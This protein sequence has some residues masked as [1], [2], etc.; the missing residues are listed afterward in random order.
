MRCRPYPAFFITLYLILFCTVG[1]S[2]AQSKIT[3]AFRYDDFS[4]ISDSVIEK[5]VAELF[6]KYNFKLTAGVIPFGIEEVNGETRIHPLTQRKGE[7]LKEYSDKGVFDIALHGFNHTWRINGEFAG[8]DYFEQKN[9]LSDGRQQIFDAVGIEASTFIPPWNRNDLNTLKALEDLSFKCIS[10][11]EHCPAK[12]SST[13]SFVPATCEL[14]ELKQA[15]E[16]SRSFKDERPIIVVLFHSED[17]IEVDKDFGSMSLPEL[18]QLLNWIAAQ[19][20]I[21]VMSISDIVN[22]KSCSAERYAKWKKTMLFP[23]LPNFHNY[24]NDTIFFSESCCGKVKKT[25]TLIFFSILFAAFF[26]SFFMGRVI[27]IRSR[28]VFLFTGIGIL[29]AG[30]LLTAYDLKNDQLSPKLLGCLV[31]LLSALIG[32]TLSYLSLRRKRAAHL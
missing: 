25:N 28:A 26:V 32:L 14:T 17:F 18:D 15:I 1:S 29:S 24:F 10:S 21:Q 23:R 19:N 8:L 4:E 6:Q 2:L 13:L 30:C 5:K 12:P 11:N 31:I 7:F 22:S 3:I 27:W 16:S 20:E 9:M